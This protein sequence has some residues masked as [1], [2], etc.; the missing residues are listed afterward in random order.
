MS[1]I[2]YHNNRAHDFADHR[3]SPVEAI[4]ILHVEDDALVAGVVRDVLQLD[5]WR[6]EV[7]SDGLAG[8]R[9]IE[10]AVPYDL[11]LL[12]NDL[13]GMNGLELTRRARMLAHRQQ[14]PIIMLS[15]GLIGRDARRA[16]V[17]VFLQ[18]PEQVMDITDVVK[19]LLL[20]S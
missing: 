8:L 6:V 9:R 13:P 11:F 10:S 2:K 4:N 7:C 18:K 3:A 12:D 5:G 16:G 19:S 20:L 17:D 14:T 15:A 1:L